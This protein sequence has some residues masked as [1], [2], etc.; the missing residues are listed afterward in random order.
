MHSLGTNIIVAFTSNQVCSQLYNKVYFGN[1]VK[2]S[3][4]STHPKGR[5]RCVYIVYG[6]YKA[7]DST[8][9]GCYILLSSDTPQQC[10]SCI[11][12]CSCYH[13][14]NSTDWKPLDVVKCL[15][16]LRMTKGSKQAEMKSSCPHKGL[17]PFLAMFGICHDPKYR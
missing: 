4:R 1:Y 6:L 9:S 8:V 12:V 16:L 7:I 13:I 14:I 15:P 17:L 5:L 2:L 11:A 3:I 10:N